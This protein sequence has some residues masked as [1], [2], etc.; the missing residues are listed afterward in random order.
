[1]NYRIGDELE[2]IGYDTMFTMGKVY[3]VDEVYTHSFGNGVYVMGDDG[4][5]YA[6]NVKVIGYYFTNVHTYLDFEVL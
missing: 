5:R 6:Y 4:V 2:C 1:M 3:M